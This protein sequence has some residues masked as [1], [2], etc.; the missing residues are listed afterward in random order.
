MRKLP[1]EK[2]LKAL[3]QMAQDFE[4]EIKEQSEKARKIAMKLEKASSKH[5]QKQAK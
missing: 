4:A 3:A 5:N 2:E 1:N